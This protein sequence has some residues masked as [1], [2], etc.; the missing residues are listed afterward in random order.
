M[1]ASVQSSHVG[2]QCICLVSD[3][4]GQPQQPRTQPMALARAVQQVSPI[5]AAEHGD[6]GHVHPSTVEITQ[7]G[8][9]LHVV[10]DDGDHPVPRV[11][12][13]VALVSAWLP[14]HC[15]PLRRLGFDVECGIWGLAM[16][17]SPSLRTPTALRDLS[18]WNAHIARR[19][20]RSGKP[21]AEG[22][23]G[24]GRVGLLIT[25]RRLMRAPAAVA[26]VPSAPPRRAWPDM[27]DRGRAAGTGRCAATRLP[28]DEGG[29]T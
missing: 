19:D 25:P 11:T 21:T 26:K 6:T 10:V 7:S 5:A 29:V 12:V 18:G 23:N 24:P 20:Q 16:A 14:A 22:V 27:T 13:E 15:T 17:V 2:L 9:E 4:L 1:V 28:L 8:V 3:P